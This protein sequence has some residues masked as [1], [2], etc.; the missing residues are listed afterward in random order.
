MRDIETRKDI[1]ILIDHFYRKAVTDEQIGFFFTEVVQLDFEKHMPV[2]YDF[3]ESIL[4]GSR[5]YQGNPMTK[6]L[7][8]N[9]KAPLTEKH[10]THWLELWGETIN[11]LYTGPK[12]D[13]ALT[14]A[15]HIGNLMQHKIQ[16]QSS[17]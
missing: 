13:E 14:R 1:E 15:Q 10:F 6:H 3:W 2:M 12:A 9:R 4:L 11:S 16:Q 8:L 17:E 5:T 7:D